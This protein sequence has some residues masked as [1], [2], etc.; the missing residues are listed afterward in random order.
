MLGS[1]NRI[2]EGFESGIDNYDG[3]TGVCSVIKNDVKGGERALEMG[4]GSFIH[5]VDG[6]GFP[7]DPPKPGDKWEIYGNN[8]NGRGYLIMLFGIQD[9][10]NYYQA[11]IDMRTGESD[12]MY[13]GYLDGGNFTKFATKTR[14]DPTK[15][16]QYRRLKIEWATN[17]T[18]T[19][20]VYTP[21]GGI[22]DSLSGTDTRFA[23]GGFGWKDSVNP[24]R[25]DSA[26]ILNR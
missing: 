15:V 3:D 2:F 19:F 8:P 11:A 16:D 14:P 24:S 10:N 20:T 23:S 17:G 4:G 7:S 9:T 26:R 1:Q 6:S 22:L 18:M 13:L 25:Y 5:V 12:E 21:S